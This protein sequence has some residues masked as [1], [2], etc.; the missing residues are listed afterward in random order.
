MARDPKADP[1]YNPEFSPEVNEVTN[2]FVYKKTGKQ[3]TGDAIIVRPRG[4][5]F[6]VLLIERK[7]GPHQGGLA[8]PG[9]FKEGADSVEDFVAR[10]ALEETGLTNKDIKETIDLPTKTDRFDWDV[11]FAD[12]V[13]VSGK[14]FMVDD[15]FIP[16]AGDDAVSAKFV[17]VEDI[18]SGKVDIAF[19]HSEW[20][21][22]TSQKLDSNY[23]GTSELQE[24][25]AKDR[26]R[27]IDFMREINTK[28]AIDNK[29]LMPIDQSTPV[30]DA[31]KEKFVQNYI[32]NNQDIDPKLANE[33]ALTEFDTRYSFEIDQAQGTFN[34]GKIEAGTMNYAPTEGFYGGE[35]R[36]SAKVPTP[37]EYK[38]ELDLYN[39]IEAKNNIPKGSIS[40]VGLALDPIAEGLEFALKGAGM[41][42]IAQWW[43][44]AEA[45]NFLAGLIRGAGAAS[46]VAQLGQSQALMGEEFTADAD[47]IKNAFA[48]NLG[49]QMKLSPSLW[50][51]NK[52]AESDLG[53]GETPSEQAFGW[54]KN[55]FG[56]SQ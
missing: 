45:A 36:H 24:I 19:L 12:G 50:M 25:V 54:V 18:A 7:R 35:Q 17:P 31:A 8:L 52:Y 13:D 4:G 42:A 56:A 15:S 40:K 21:Y 10:E 30:R 23:S 44:K 6:D 5:S 20:I 11:R 49:N 37:P 51:E 39:A 14:I 32:A 26:K 9:G 1:Y 53:K 34:A 46:G 29:P 22:D 55:M 47:A 43:V 33:R 41:G 27:N 2:D 3:T 16:K 48:Q 28:R 38:N